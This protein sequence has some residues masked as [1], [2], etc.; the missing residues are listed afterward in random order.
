MR[1][2]GRRGGVLGGG[3]AT[4]L[5]TK[6]LGAVVWYMLSLDGGDRRALLDLSG[7]GGVPSV[8]R[9]SA[10]EMRGSGEW[11]ARCPATAEPWRSRPGDDAWVGKLAAWMHVLMRATVSRSLSVAATAV[12]CQPCAA[13]HCSSA[14]SAEAAAGEAAPGE[15][16]DAAAA[17]VGGRVTTIART[18]APL[19]AAAAGA[20]AVA[21]R[22]SAHSPP[23]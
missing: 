2:R 4:R 12:A 11:R 8:A 23:G 13:I 16:A 10:V 17:L 22:R 15:E 20:A 21:R 7:K 1:G 5:R 18:T 19:G 6:G 3:D 14:S 9:I